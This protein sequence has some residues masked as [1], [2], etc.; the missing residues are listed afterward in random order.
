ME[1]KKPIDFSKLLKK[2]IV[3]QMDRNVDNCEENDILNGNSDEDD[4]D[5]QKITSPW[6]NSFAELKTEMVPLPRHNDIYKRIMKEGDGEV[7]GTR[8]CRIQWIYSMFF[9]SAEHSFDSSHCGKSHIRTVMSDELLEGVWL[10]LETMRKGEEAHFVIGYKFMF[11]EFGEMTSPFKI[12]P[13][14]DVLLVAKLCDFEEIGSADACDKLTD[15]ELHH[16]PTVKLKAVEMQKQLNELYRS[17]RF[18]DAILLSLD[19]IQRVQFCDYQSEDEQ[20]DKYAFLSEIY[21]TLIDCYVK[22][23]KFVKAIDA[24]KRM[25]QLVNVERFVDV[26]IN[27]AIALSRIHDDYN[28]SIA[29]LLKAQKLYPR[30]ELVKDTLNDLQKAREKYHN[31]TK[32]FMRKA[33]QMKSQPTITTK[34]SVKE[35]M[36]DKIVQMIKS[37]KDCDIGTGIPLVGCTPNELKLYENAINKSPELT[38]QSVTDHNGTIQHVIKRSL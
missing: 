6:L 22:K 19:I 34:P 16:Y 20:N 36:D 30:N 21:I 29:L 28:P 32:N 26:L 14:A 2:P 18:S 13:K 15:E 37:L 12:K 17:H 8:L 25:R 38:L 7:L 1:L 10:A 5:D 31:D 9:E 24:V 11:G 23:E 3:F 4:I 35:N 27:E 33:F